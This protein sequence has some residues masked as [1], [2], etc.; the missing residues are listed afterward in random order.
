[1]TWDVAGDAGRARVGGGGAN[2]RVDGV[3]DDENV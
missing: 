2:G 1:M 3:T